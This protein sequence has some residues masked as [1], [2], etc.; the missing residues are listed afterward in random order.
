MD[1][2][3]YIKLAA[4]TECINIVQNKLFEVGYEEEVKHYLSLRISP[5]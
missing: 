3:K 5:K 2:R 1:K 4:P